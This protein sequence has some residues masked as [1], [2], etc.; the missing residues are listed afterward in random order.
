MS[1]SFFLW[2]GAT[3]L[4]CFLCRNILWLN[5]ITI[6]PM[7]VRREDIFL[8]EMSGDDLEDAFKVDFEDALCPR[9]C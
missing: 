8:L 4:V 6:L 5:K 9:A 2:L 7:P 3:W 1:L